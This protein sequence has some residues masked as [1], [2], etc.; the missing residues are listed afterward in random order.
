MDQLLHKAK[1]FRGLSFPEKVEFVKELK[2]LGKVS[3]KEYEASCST[4]PHTKEAL[5]RPCSLKKCPFW[6]KHEFTKNCALNYMASLEEDKLT[7]E[8]ISFL[9]EK[10][11]AR[12]ESLNKDALKVVQRVFLK[13]LLVHKEVP[14]FNFIEGFCVKCQTKLT[15]DDFEDP[16]MSLGDGFG[17]CSRECK[18]TY[19]PDIWKVEKFFETDLLTL[20]RV[21]AELFNFYYLEEILGF[22][23]NV[24]RNRLDKLRKT[25]KEY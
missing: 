2:T 22:Q 13:D 21:G 16:S 24:L 17:Y 12:V 6:V 1:N 15:E 7:L 8:Q 9:F 14:R 20:V 18:R 10:N 11:L 3:N 23:P 4:C 19:L 25:G 5:V